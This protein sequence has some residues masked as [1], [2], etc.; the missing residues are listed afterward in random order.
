MPNRDA[1]SKK[2]KGLQKRIS[3]EKGIRRRPVKPGR[4]APVFPSPLEESSFRR[5]IEESIISGIAAF[6]NKGCQTYAN[7]AFCKMV[8][9]SPE[10]LS[11]KEPP[12]LY[13]AREDRGNIARA[14]RN[15]LEG[16]KPRGSL[17]LR[18]QRRN[19]ERFDALLLYSALTDELGRR[20]GW[21]MSASDFTQ[22]KRAEERMRRVNAGLEERVRWRTAGLE[23]TTRKLEE[24]VAEHKEMEERIAHLASFPE[25][26][27]NP[28]VEIDSNGQVVY[29]NPAAQ[30]L[31]P[32]L[33]IQ[34][35]SHPY[36]AGVAALIGPPQS[37]KDISLVR[38]QEAG[39]SWYHQSV[40][41]SSQ[42]NR[43][44]IYGFDITDQKRAEEAIRESERKF[45]ELFEGSR[46]GYAHVDMDGN[47]L[48]FNTS[49]Q[50]M[51]GY[52]EEE[53]KRLSYL[54]LT[55]RK[56]H[57]ME[58]DIIRNQVLPHGYSK[59]YEK[60]YRRK[61]G[62]IFPVSLR[63]YL[64]QDGQGNPQ[65]M[66]AFIR[67]ITERKRM[68]DSLTAAN[69]RLKILSEIASRLLES[70]KPQEVVEELCRKV[71]DHLD[72]HTF[73]NFL[74]DEE[75]KRLH[76]NAYAGIPDEEARK[77]EWLDFG[78]AVCGCAARDGVRI[79]TENIP[80]TLD[81]RTDL[82]RS[83]GIKAYACHPLLSQGKVIGTLSFGTRSRFYFSDDDLS[84][85][86]SV[87]DQ[88]S[89]AMERIR[90][91]EMASRRAEEL[92]R[93]VRERTQEL[94]ERI[95][96]LDC[97][98]KVSGLLNEEDTFQEDILQRTVEVIP[99]GWQFPEIACARAVFR[100]RE[101][102]T[103][104]FRETPWLQTS[105]VISEGRQLGILEVGYLEERPGRDEGPFLEEERTLLDALADQLGEFLERNKA[106]EAVRES[107]E[108]LEG[109][110]SSIDLLIAHMDSNFN[111]IR[112]NRAYAEAD[113]RT[114]DFYIG[115]NHFA[116]FPSEENEAIFRRVLETGK[117]FHAA[118][119]P[120]SYAEHPERGITYWDW[121]LHPVKEA[122][123]KVRGV[124][125]NLVNVTDRKKAEEALKRSSLYTRGLIEA[126]P[127]PLVTIS[128]EGKITDVNRATELVTGV[129][130][131]KIIG[132]DFS[133]Y[134]TDPVKAREGYEEVFKKGSVR[135]YPLAIR[136][137]SG[138]VTD[139][140]YNATV[141]R[142]EAGE[143]QG[144]FAA[145]RDITQRKRAE[146]ALRQNEQLLRNVL[147]LLPVGVWIADKDGV[148]TYGNPAGHQIWAGYRYVGIEQFGEYKG[149]WLNTGKKIEPQ[150]WAVA[151]A[152][153]KG[154]TSL[155]EEIEIE[156]FDG[157]HKIILNSAL[158]LRNDKNEIT[159]AFII[160]DDITERRQAEQRIRQ[161][162]KMEALG[163]LAGGIAHDFNN[164][165][166]PIVINT[167]LALLDVKKGLLPSPSYM[168]LVKE[169][170]TRGQGLVKQI[171]TF[172]RQREQPRQPV[173]INPVIKEALKFLR[174]SIPKNNEIRSS[175]EV[176]PA[177]ILADPTQIHQ[178]LMNLC[179][180]AAFAMRGKEG[181]LR[182]SLSRVEI[183]PEGAS[184]QV[185]VKP[186]PYLRLTVSDTGHGMDPEVKNRAFDP[187]FTTKKP[188]EG[189]GM[190]LAVVHGI[191]KNHEGVI[192]LESELGKGTTVHVFLPWAQA[193]GPRADVSAEP[194]PMGKERILLIDD[195][196]IQVR[197]LQHML[198]RLGYRV[199]AKTRAPEALETFRTQPDAFDLVI[200]DQTMPELSGANLAREILQIR[201][202]MPVILYTGYSET[203][204][205]EEARSIGIRDFALK[206]LTV[207]DMA[208]RIRRA[209]KK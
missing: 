85:M 115:K 158:P 133:D 209:L 4:E 52:E 164:L 82:V 169:A 190:G 11:G 114:P 70:E 112:V 165:L 207:R 208:E 187:F 142:N 197:T 25:L 24:K 186:G 184:R 27:P 50:K 132:R 140:L 147:E 58:A 192:T 125:L 92:D 203:L 151:R 22:Q 9:W 110:F 122:D 42:W 62:T 109:I 72:C 145:A 183:D 3:P 88:V 152:I 81:P 141:Y 37:Q 102:R 204:A 36:L 134:F 90:L 149:W 23:S 127:D 181:T 97:L 91:Y 182:V 117:P 87:A 135:D 146:E 80:E 206:P 53:L 196:E 180:N 118:E 19:G 173:D 32:D 28:V 21:V 66:W 1:D 137:V 177:V 77:I 65:G 156:C 67:D 95:K 12:F 175:I 46:D 107:N 71:M 160:N 170:A 78:V 179:S 61:D 96:E 162:Q 144:V 48:E 2:T 153:Q 99:S 116:L 16:A 54:D 76:L 148:I 194:I 161:M 41:F 106:H 157:S 18:F 7:E 101:Y 126:S 136:H 168:Q 167:E 195:E 47:L 166:M 143:V 172:S 150:E 75:K 8:G 73:F 113:G 185:D 188:G 98:C 84:L 154:E 57:E 124:V 45:R 189:T 6:D 29:Q 64:F 26:N 35:S 39:P 176:E 13:W 128:P 60:E 15:I 56:W 79:V 200:T 89:M 104:N 119:K 33:S 139:V 103:Q 20:K 138:K 38:E 130:R 201:P 155:N 43:I 199:M 44:R 198:E 34:G 94:S 74:V 14:F 178:V 120:F 111:F 121:S 86:R 83:Y 30:R 55:P 10:E 129:P 163:K 171:I 59:V 93:I 202:D 17:E 100:G 5:A 123:G 105:A 174:A 68:A 108:I 49:F 31:F 63:T 69:E 193:D 159:G 51:L 191:V 205:E 131:K 40:H